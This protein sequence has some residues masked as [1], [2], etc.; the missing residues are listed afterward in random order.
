[1]TTSI[2]GIRRRALR[3]SRDPGR[4]AQ[5]QA[6]VRGSVHGASRTL[7]DPRSR[8]H[9]RAAARHLRR[10]TR[11]AQRIGI[12]KAVGDPRVKWQLWRGYQHAVAAA[13]PPPSRVVRRVVAGGVV[14]GLV[15][16]GAAAGI[17]RK[18]PGSAGGVED[19]DLVEDRAD[20]DAAG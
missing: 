16:G 3:R 17:A 10:A 1:M 4:L 2:D 20:G 18:R 15:V 13:K 5:I 6:S 12:G 8:R 7:H 19:A 14:A 11:R 9:Q